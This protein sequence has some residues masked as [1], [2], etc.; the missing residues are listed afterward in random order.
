MFGSDI[1]VAP[2]L[3]QGAINRPVYL[4]LGSSWKDPS[5]GYQYEGGQWIQSEAPLDTMP[6]FLRDGADLPING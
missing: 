1:L 5:T 4:P 6:L 2:I 3:N